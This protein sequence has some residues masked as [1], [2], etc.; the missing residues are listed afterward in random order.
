MAK[1]LFK[2]KSQEHLTVRS[3]EVSGWQKIFANKSVRYDHSE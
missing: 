1:F 3:P 2:I